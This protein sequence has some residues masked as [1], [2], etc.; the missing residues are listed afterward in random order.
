M[1]RR[2]SHLSDLGESQR[3]KPTAALRQ[4]QAQEP[5]RQAVAVQL[6]PEEAVWGNGLE[7]QAEALNGTQLLVAQRNSLAAQIAQV[8]G[9]RHLG[10]VLG[11]VGPMNGGNGHAVQRQDAPG[12]SVHPMIRYGSRG[13]DVEEAQTKLNTA[14]ATPP[15]AVDGIFGPLTRAATVA[16]QTS[17]NLSPDGIIGPLTWGALDQA[18]GSP[19]V[20]VPEIPGPETPGPETPGPETPGP[21]TPGPE[22]PGPETPGPETPGPETP[23]ERWSADDST[24]LAAQASDTGPLNVYQASRAELRVLALS[25][26]EY[27]ELRSLLDEAGSDMEWAFLLKA[28][29]AQRSISDISAF[30]VRIRGMSERWL[31]R[32]LMVVD[33]VNDLSPD[34]DPEERGIM[35]QY[36][37]SCGPTSVQLIHAQ[38]DPI[39][40][41]ELRS[42]GPVDQAPDQAVTNPE[43]ITN[44]QLASEQ[45]GILN[46][47]AA[48]GTGNAPTDRTSPT[49]GAWVESDL[50][51]VSS[52][53]GV[54]YTTKIIGTD[55]TAAAAMSEL[56]NGLASGVH[57]PIVVGGGLGPSNTSHYVVVLIAAGGR[58]LVHDVATGES[59]WRT[60]AQFSSNTLDLPSGWNFFVAIDVPSLTPPPLPQPPA[61]SSG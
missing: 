9:N 12:P 13:P 4:N 31:M 58:F 22:T 52:A 10:Q 19:E 46:T 34:A 17:H 14:G 11:N 26:S 27:S 44:E 21:E 23:V 37:N 56:Q 30:A 25:E 1:P 29:A 7:G 47:H 49:G 59:V 8:Q 38:A 60:E 32:N 33:L 54:T 3:K 55:I 18:S 43:S 28:T 6:M 57:I 2:R 35:Q 61:T 5:A 20:P 50:A 16:F 48:A 53:T 42:G 39:Y 15:L 24:R 51:A 36:G 40:A 45:A 41:L